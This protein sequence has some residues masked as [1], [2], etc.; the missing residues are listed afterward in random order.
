MAP[1]CSYRAEPLPPD[2]VDPLEAPLEVP[3]DPVEPLEPLAPV[4]SLVPDASLV[5]DEPLLLEPCDPADPDV[6]L[7]L[8]I[9][10][11]PLVPREPLP[12]A[13]QP[14]IIALARQM[15]RKTFG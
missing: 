8:D 4:E 11:L 6:L 5:P 7:P 14:A 10:L 12:V 15:T 9:P 2:P 1:S 13:L 3:L